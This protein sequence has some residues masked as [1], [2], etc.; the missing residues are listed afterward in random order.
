[1][2]GSFAD[3]VDNLNSACVDA[4]GVENG[5][6]ALARYTRKSGATMDMNGIYDEAWASVK[7]ST[8]RIGVPI[9]TTKPHF[10]VPARAFTDGGKPLQGETLT[11]LAT[12]RNFRI[13]DVSP[14]GFDWFLLNLT[15]L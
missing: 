10:S 9:S 1:M 3:A 6:S 7:M 12:G 14:D 4:F 11:I 8:G 13:A 15:E 2:P 5:T